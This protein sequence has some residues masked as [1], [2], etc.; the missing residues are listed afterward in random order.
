MRSHTVTRVCRSMSII[1]AAA[2]C[3]TSAGQPSTVVVEDE[4]G[5]RVEHDHGE[6]GEETS[7]LDRPVEELFAASCEHGKKTF[8]CDECRYEVGVAKAPASL[9]DGGLLEA[10]KVERRRV[11]VPLRLTGEVQLDE[12]RVAH[13]SSQVE[14]IIR[15]VH[16]ILGDHVEPGQPLVEVESVE[17]G[18]AR[19]SHSEALGRLELAQATFDRV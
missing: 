15:D 7:D 17:V 6:E 12:R 9:F 5:S 2:A 14:G 13:V 8:E 4:H 11:E 16:V 3:S 10:V 19:V 1:A 18:E